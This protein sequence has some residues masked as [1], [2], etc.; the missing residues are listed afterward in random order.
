ME[1]WPKERLQAKK[2]FDVVHLFLKILIILI[3]IKYDKAKKKV[4]HKRTGCGKGIWD[5]TYHIGS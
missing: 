4:I 3:P 2:R 1:Q 5:K